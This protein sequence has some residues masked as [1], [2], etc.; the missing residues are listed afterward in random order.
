MTT[1]DYY[2]ETAEAYDALHDQEEEHAKAFEIGWPL[3][4]Q[5]VRS[6]LDVGC[7]TGRGLS[8]LSQHDPALELY[9]IEPAQAMLEIA[10]SKLNN[11]DLREGSGEDLPFQD[12]SIDVI[13]ATGIMHHVD[14]PSIVISEMF[15][16][17]RKAVLISDHN[18]YAFGG[19]L[20]RRLRIILKAIYL[21]D[22]AAYVKQGFNR[23]GW[24]EDDGWWYPYSLFDSYGDIA[25]KAKQIFVYPTRPPSQNGNVLFS[26]SHFAVLSL[27]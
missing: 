23:R 24:S 14:D 11:A 26:Q 22:A 16:V 1:T 3:I 7:G 8:W 27:L 18:N 21:F 19:N 25:T 13:T 2:N 5:N 6:V 10:R 9:G 15:R 12:H 17:A 4:G 20:S